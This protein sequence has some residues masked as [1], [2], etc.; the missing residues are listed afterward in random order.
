MV[1]RSTI[2]VAGPDWKR[3]WGA[4]TP[5]YNATDKHCTPSR[6]FKHILDQQPCS[7]P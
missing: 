3:G 5:K 7:R 4:N 6:H 1:V 2:H